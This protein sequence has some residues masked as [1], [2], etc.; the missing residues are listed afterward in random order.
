MKTRGQ[1]TM[2]M[3]SRIAERR[4]ELG[5]SQQ[6]L[7][8]LLNVSFQSVS[9]W[10]RE[11]CLPKTEKLPEIAKVLSINTSWLF[12]E[13]SAQKKNWVLNNQM[14]DIEH[15]INLIQKYARA[16]NMHE[17]L[18]AL[19][20]MQ[21]Y[22]EGQYRKGPGKI[23]YIA[24]PLTLACHGFALGIGDDNLIAACLLHDVLEDCDVEAGELDVK[25]EI[26]VAVQL[27][28]FKQEEGQSK[29][30]AKRMYF[31]RLEENPTA[32]MVKLLD[33]CNNISNMAYAFSRKKLASYIDETEKYVL[34]L[35][36]YVKHEY[37]EYYDATFL[38]KYH[39]VSVMESVKCLL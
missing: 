35:L 28:S 8:E 6:Q 15:M 17:T 38:I 34:P 18:K 7:A 27:L 22:H 5:L 24:H 4:K 37:Y 33:R 10:E 31:K 12:E 16:K 36:D 26:T 14:F 2:S 13:E 32:C 1:C 21:K 19:R 29:D 39:L 20:L 9:L 25:P 11:V 30:E 23:P 3:G